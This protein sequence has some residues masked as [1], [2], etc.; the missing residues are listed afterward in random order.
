M[1]GVLLGKVFLVREQLLEKQDA[2]S[3]EE[4]WL[5]ERAQTLLNYLQ[6]LA[7]AEGLGSAEGQGLQ[8]ATAE[9]AEG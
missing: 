7:H 6:G 8:N 5:S 9:G 3:L 2:G 1:T 4:V